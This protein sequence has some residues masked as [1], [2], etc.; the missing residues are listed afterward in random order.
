MEV[1]T[2]GQK[3]LYVLSAPVCVT[4]G[5]FIWRLAKRKLDDNESLLE[6]FNW[7]YG[8]TAGS[9]VVKLLTNVLPHASQVFSYYA[10]AVS[11]AVIT[12]LSM[13]FVQ[14]CTRVWHSNESYVSPGVVTEQQEP[15][16]NGAGGMVENSHIRVSNLSD[17][18][19]HLIKAQDIVKDKTKRRVI[20]AVLYW[21]I[22]YL[23]VLDGFFSVYWSDKSPAGP[24][25]VSALSWVNRL[26]DSCVIYCGL[27]HALIPNISKTRWYKWL[28]SYSFLSFVWLLALVL[29]TL[30]AL[31][32]MSVD[33]AASIVTHPAWAFCYGLGG[34]ILLWM[35]TYFTW[36]TG[37]SPTR[38]SVK[39][40]LAITTSVLVIGTLAGMFT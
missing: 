5:F 10:L 29:S 8:I 9:L 39:R 34:G 31:V 24:W 33:Q 12:F 26:L 19:D 3:A 20:V 38:G 4:L 32:N 23:T 2:A 7:L 36:L 17:F 25:G 22:V 35:T 16:L 18:R 1:F 21:T 11:G 40:R 14:Q 6:R 13:V 27:V 15:L 28:F 30:P 37:P